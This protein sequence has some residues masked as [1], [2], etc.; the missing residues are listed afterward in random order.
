MTQLRIALTLG[1]ALFA[2]GV[3]SA[4]TAQGQQWACSSTDNECYDYS[5]IGA[6][7]DPMYPCELDG[8][9]A[10]T[11]HACQ[12]AV[13]LFDQFGSQCAWQTGDPTT[14][15][16]LGNDGNPTNS[17]C[18]H[19]ACNDQ[20]QCVTTPGADPD[21]SNPECSIGS[22]TDCTHAAC[23][24]N[25]VCND[26][27]PGK[28]PNKGEPGAECD[29][30]LMCK[31][32]ECNS[33]ATCS[34]VP[35]ID[36]GSGGCWGDDSLCQHNECRQNSSGGWYCSGGIAGGWVNDCDIGSGDADCV[37]AECQTDSNGVPFCA[38]TVPG[39]GGD[40]CTFSSD[41]YECQ[42]QGDPC[43]GSAW[44][45]GY[46]C[47]TQCNSSH[48][49][50]TVSPSS[51]QCTACQYGPP[52]TSYS[53]PQCIGNYVGMWKYTTT[54]DCQ[55]NTEPILSVE[56][57]TSYQ[58]YGSGQCQTVVQQTGCV[59]IG[60]VANTVFTCGAINYYSTCSGG[61]GSPGDNRTC[62]CTTSGTPFQTFGTSGWITTDDC[63]SDDC[64]MNAAKTAS[65][66]SNTPTGGPNGDT[67]CTPGQTNVCNGCAEQIC[68]DDGTWGSCPPTHNVCDTVAGQCACAVGSGT[69]ECTTYDQCVDSCTVGQ[70]AQCG[71]CG[72]KTCI[73][74]GWN[75]GMWG[76]C[77]DDPNRKL[78]CDGTNTCQCVSGTGDDS[79]NVQGQECGTTAVCA[80]GE[81]AGVD[82]NDCTCKC[83]AG[84]GN[85]E[86][87]LNQIDETCSGTC[88]PGAVLS[89]IPFGTK[90]CNGTGHWDSCTSYHAECQS[91]TCTYVDGAGTSDCTVGQAC[92]TACSAGQH[93]ACQN[94]TCACVDGVGTD[95]CT[96]GQSCTSQPPYVANMSVA[97][98]DCIGIA[99]RSQLTLQW[100][101]HDQEQ[102]PQQMFVLQASPQ[103]SFNDIVFSRSVLISCNPA[104]G[105]C[106]NSFQVPIKTNATVNG[107]N[108]DVGDICALQ[109]G[110]S[111]NYYFR[112]RVV[113]NSGDNDIDHWYYYDGNGQVTE[114]SNQAE[115]F[116]V[117]DHPSPFAAFAFSPD[118]PKTKQVVNFTDFSVCYDSSLNQYPCK[119]QNG[120]TYAWQFGT[121]GTSSTKGNTT[122]IFNTEGY[123]SVTLQ[124]CDSLNCCS[125]GQTIPVTGPKGNLPNYKEISPF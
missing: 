32:F 100:E 53:V 72:L 75:G 26:G 13:C 63:P 28:G 14:S 40:Q 79:C 56:C 39:N 45:N 73:D 52:G 123:K 21:P 76:A 37:H 121:E 70:T 98:S 12:H 113:A 30:D 5:F 88:T 64:S 60:P 95:S 66:P 106:T 87:V 78:A 62:P 50:V 77:G 1:L 51:G 59:Q 8:S 99:G 22:L 25:G 91:N 17:K 114:N 112:V 47:P 16:C 38:V 81:H 86:C 65:N 6:P 68:K 110:T 111:N 125:F 46:D 35:G 42:N 54:Y 2:I 83:L 90:T 31:H 24:S 102:D 116:S 15:N 4:G 80:S 119:N 82:Q 55:Y 11:A 34:L 33:N 67:Y 84:A 92:P 9:G 109:F 29:D 36:D 57:P 49:C 122:F 43:G 97:E 96:V 107:C 20:G 74:S 23:T 18:S 101:Y 41:C 124:A 61:G 48:T 71:T 58:S 103:K 69:D 115:F 89:C 10:P 94:G 108:E 118:V 104:A 117:A 19:P 44:I 105:T 120:N 3:F 7:G 93:A 85:D 27:A